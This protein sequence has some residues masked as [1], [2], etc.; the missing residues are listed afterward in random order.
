M[1]NNLKA[2]EDLYIIELFNKI[3][4]DEEHTKFK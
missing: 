1:R 2:K 3:Y 4:N